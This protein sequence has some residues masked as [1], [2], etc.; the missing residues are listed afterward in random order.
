MTLDRWTTDV[1]QLYDIVHAYH[2]HQI[3]DYIYQNAIRHF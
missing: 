1:K 3:T 2:Q